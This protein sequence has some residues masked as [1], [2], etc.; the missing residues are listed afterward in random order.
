MERSTSL[1]LS[2]RKESMIHHVLHGLRVSPTALLVN[3]EPARAA[4][5]E[6]WSG[7]GESSVEVEGHLYSL[8]DEGSVNLRDAQESDPT[9]YQPRYVRGPSVLL[10]TGSTRRYWWRKGPPVT[11]WRVLGQDGVRIA[12]CSTREEAEAVV[13][14]VEETAALLGPSVSVSRFHSR[15]D[16]TPVEPTVTADELAQ[17]MSEVFFPSPEPDITYSPNAP[18]VRAEPRRKGCK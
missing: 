18:Q 13:Q 8:L 11:S 10:P 16:P 17:R 2:V 7:N 14:L 15:E 9:E 6:R 1:L 3:G 12:L 4:D 5:L